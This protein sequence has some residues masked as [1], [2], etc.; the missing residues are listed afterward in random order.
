MI[1]LVALALIYIVSFI[2]LVS[3]PALGRQSSLTPQDHMDLHDA[4]WEVRRDA[5]EHLMALPGAPLLPPVQESLLKLRQLENIASNKSTPDLF[6]DDDYLAYDEQLTKSVQ[7]IAVQTNNHLAWKSLVEMRYNGDSEQGKW[8]ASHRQSL[9]PLKQL[10]RSP[11][12]PRRKNAVYA[13]AL[14]LKYN[15]GKS[16]PS[17]AKYRQL[18]Q[19]IR[20]HVTKDIPP[21]QYS[22][23][24]GL[25]LIDDPR[26]VPFLEAFIKTTDDETLKSLA[27]KTIVAIRNDHPRSF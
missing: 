19:Q 2:T 1:R 3:V 9:M 8:L 7:E 26:D 25:G 13:I 23:I 20:S 24:E 5:Y 17:P 21:V 27:A 15:H 16:W 10:L 14:L 11:H 12:S 6:E 18:V 22:A 4:R